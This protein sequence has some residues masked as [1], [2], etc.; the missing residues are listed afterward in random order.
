MASKQIPIVIVFVVAV[1]ILLDNFLPGA[2][3]K[4]VASELLT[5]AI[6]LSAFAFVVGAMNLIQINVRK[7]QR[8]TKDWV[9]AASLMTGMVIFLA[10][11]LIGGGPNAPVYKNLFQYILSPYSQAFWA[12]VLFFLVSATYRGFVAKRW[13]A[14]VIL[15]SGVIFMLGAVPVGDVLIPGISKISKW[16][17]DVPNNGGQRGI[18]VGAAVGAIILQIRVILGL[19]RGHFGG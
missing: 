10:A 11:G 14:L 18:I 17:Q 2:A 4:P 13:Q 16:I 7:I 12:V 15:I 1:I 3:T 8:K 6:V 9:H 19:E 5:W